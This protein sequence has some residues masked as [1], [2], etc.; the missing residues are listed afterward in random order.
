MGFARVA[1]KSTVLDYLIGYAHPLIIEQHFNACRSGTV[2]GRTAI[3]FV[4]AIEL[5][6]VIL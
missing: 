6:T 4:A 2:M 5:T 1:M 3:G